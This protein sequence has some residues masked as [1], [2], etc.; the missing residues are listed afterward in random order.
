MTYP[1]PSRS[2]M[3]TFLF[4][5]LFTS[6]RSISGAISCLNYAATSHHVPM[7][8][9]I[10]SISSRFDMSDVKRKHGPEVLELLEK[11]VKRV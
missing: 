11:Q 6:V 1:I 10:V 2:V 9:Y 5:L 4:F 8:P 7:I 3:F